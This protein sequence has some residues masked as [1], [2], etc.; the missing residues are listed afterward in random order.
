MIARFVSLIVLFG[1][2]YLGR[3]LYKVD[4]SGLS[5]VTMDLLMPPF[6]FLSVVDAPISWSDVMHPAAACVFVICGTIALAWA[7]ARKTGL[8]LLR[9]VMPVAFMNSGFLGIP[10]AQALGGAA[11]VNKVIIFDQTMNLIIFTV[12]ITIL[13]ANESLKA[14][15][16]NFI[17]NPNLLAIG[18]AVAWKAFGPPLPHAMRTIISLPAAATIPLALFSM[19]AALPS[20]REVNKTALVAGAIGRY[21]AGAVLATIYCLIFRP[22]PMTA[23]VILLISTTSSAVFSF[24]LSERYDVEPDYA[25]GVVFVTTMAYPLVFPLVNILLANV[26]AGLV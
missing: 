17:A 8:P 5:R 18:L 21:A 6:I 12:G 14:G 13:G 26:I 25:A 1:L 16:R 9:F 20:L 11:W 23:R 3:R 2:G 10:M 7:V 24:I 19:G 22:D 4:A 15:I